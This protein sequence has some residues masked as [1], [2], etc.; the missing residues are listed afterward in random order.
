MACLYGLFAWELPLGVIRVT[1]LELACPIVLICQ[2]L[3]SIVN[4]PLPGSKTIKSGSKLL[5]GI[6]G[7]A[8]IKQSSLK[9]CIK[10]SATFL[11]LEFVEE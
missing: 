10:A 9:W 8:Q 11:S 4:S 7:L 2:P 6:R 3:T 1:E 5:G